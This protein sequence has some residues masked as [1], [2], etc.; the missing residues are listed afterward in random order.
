MSMVEQRHLS[1]FEEKKN[2]AEIAA[3]VCKI[4]TPRAKKNCTRLLGETWT[5][6]EPYFLHFYRPTPANKW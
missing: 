4:Y 2:A 6:L 3:N 1:R 5:V